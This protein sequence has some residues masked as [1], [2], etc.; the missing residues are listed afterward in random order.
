MRIE[1]RSVGT[2]LGALRLGCCWRYVPVSEEPADA[3][4]VYASVSR[5]KVPWWW[6]GVDYLW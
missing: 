3:V 1:H 6:L 2:S 4:S 5:C